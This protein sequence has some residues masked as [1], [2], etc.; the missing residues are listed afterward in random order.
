MLTTRVRTP[1]SSGQA[2]FAS[3]GIAKVVVTG[4]PL[5]ETP[6]PDTIIEDTNVSNVDRYSWRVSATSDNTDPVKV[7][8]AASKDVT[9]A[10]EVV[11]DRRY[12]KSVALEGQ[13][14]VIAQG[15]QNVTVSSVQVR[16][17]LFPLTSNTIKFC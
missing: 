14:Q 15:S 13:V 5:S 11:R 9:V 10:V 17:L 8:Q 1:D 4:C 3:L 12:S 7:R 16:L 2:P 6:K